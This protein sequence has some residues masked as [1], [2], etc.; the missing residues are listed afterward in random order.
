[1]TTADNSVAGVIDNVAPPVTPPEVAVIL[2]LPALTLFA[3][4]LLSMVATAWFEEVQ[5]ATFVKSKVLPSEYVPVALSC[6]PRPRGIEGVAGVI[7]IDV[8]VGTVNGTPLLS[9]PLACTMTFPVVA[10]AGTDT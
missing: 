4:P 8:R 5:L 6:W 1:V 3:K 10:P 9:T 7:P 2:A